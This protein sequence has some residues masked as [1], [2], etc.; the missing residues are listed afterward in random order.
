M[1]QFIDAKKGDLTK[2][3]SEH[4]K[5]EMSNFHQYN[6]VFAG[7]DN[8]KCTVS[9]NFLSTHYPKPSLTLCV[10]D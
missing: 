8:K 5:E 10:H 3:I 1:Q 6:A 4:I 9:F 2:S 7:D